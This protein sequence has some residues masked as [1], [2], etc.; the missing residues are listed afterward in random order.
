MRIV[1][2]RIYEFKNYR[3]LILME[4]NQGENNIKWWHKGT[5][6][7]IYPLSFKDSSGNG[8][9][10]IPGI[11]SKLDY[12]AWLG[13]DAIWLSPHYPSPMKD[14]GYDVSNYIDVHPLYGKLSDMEELIEKAHYLE[15]KILLDYVPNHSSIE[16]PWFQE[17]KSSRRNSK[18][19]WYIWRDP[20]EN[21]TFPN[22]WICITGGSAW[23][24]DESTE[25]YY[26]HSFLP[27]QPDLN[28]SNPEVRKAMHDVLRFWLNRD[29]DGFRIDMI[30]WLSKDP[31]FRDDLPNPNYNPTADYGY[32][33]L[34][35]T[36]SKDGPELYEILHEFRNVLDEYEDDRIL[37]GEADY[38]SPLNILNKYYQSGINLP[39]NFRLVY[40]PWEATIIRSFIEKYEEECMS[41]VNYQFGNH[42]HSRVTSRIGPNQAR[43]AAMLLFTLSGTSFIYYGEEIGMEDVLIPKEKIFDP[44]EQT[45]PGKGR[46]PERTPMQWTPGINAGFT[47]GQPWLPIN[48]NYIQVNVETERE[49]PKSFLKL[50][51]KLINLRKSNLSLYLGK[52]KPYHNV[53]DTCFAFVR[54]FGQERHSILL[55]FSS[56]S[57][58]LTIPNLSSGVVL[59]STFLDRNDTIKSNEFTLRGNEGCIIANSKINFS[60]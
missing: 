42:D 50:Y 5:I 3:G 18:R 15:I 22:N 46:D 36:N 25:Q 16:H 54:E 32:L 21:G 48:D 14:F 27:C 34:L 59:L 39:A 35:H 1:L 60:N 24:W 9:G 4:R 38:Y 20:N 53:P 13:V 6:Y 37:I 28:W 33:K 58:E 29:V 17:S 40:L 55:N 44:W 31:E 51:K 56:K 52:F 8:K 47:G 57:Q 30:S 10:D 49:N 43:V 19:N 2:P 26:L 11:I 45:E 23:E 41:H 7:Q 12:L